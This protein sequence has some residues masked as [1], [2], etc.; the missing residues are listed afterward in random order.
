MSKS[1]AVP[2]DLY[3]KAAEIAAKDHISTDEFVTAALASHLASREFIASR[4]RLFN[5]EEFQRA[6]NEIPDVGAEE[7]DRR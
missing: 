4:A 5:R 6:L 7:H 1:V 2:E 3:N